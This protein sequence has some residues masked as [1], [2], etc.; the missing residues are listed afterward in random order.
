MNYCFRSYRQESSGGR[1]KRTGP[2]DDVMFDILEEVVDEESIKAV[3]VAM[4][5]MVDEYLEERSFEE[6]TMDLIFEVLK[7]DLVD[8]VSVQIYYSMF[9]FVTAFK[10]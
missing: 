1:Y 8:L 9:K 7:D 5:Q 4:R 6:F 2:L 3:R 10:H